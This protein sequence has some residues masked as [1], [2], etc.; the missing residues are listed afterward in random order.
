MSYG[1][2]SES[3]DR[4]NQSISRDV[5]SE[6]S[7]SRTPLAD[8]EL[9]ITSVEPH[10]ECGLWR[11]CAEVYTSHTDGGAERFQEVFSNAL[12]A[13]EDGGRLI[14]VSDSWITGDNR[15][16]S[17]LLR[18]LYGAMKEQ[19]LPV[20]WWTVDVGDTE[21]ARGYH[22]GCFS[23]YKAMQ[24]EKNLSIDPDRAREYIDTNR[25]LY[26][27]LREF[28][29]LTE[30]DW[31]MLVDIN[32]MGLGIGAADDPHRPAKVVE[33]LRIGNLGDNPVI[34][35]AWD[36]LDAL[37]VTSGIDSVLHLSSS[38]IP[39][40]PTH[41]S[42]GGFFLPQSSSFEPPKGAELLK[43][44]DLVHT[45][46]IEVSSVS[47]FW[48]SEE[49]SSFLH[50]GRDPLSLLESNAT[51]FYL[52]GRIDSSKNQALAIQAFGQMLERHPEY[53]STTALVLLSET[54]SAWNISVER[55]ALTEVL[56]E[57]FRVIDSLPAEAQ[58]RVAWFFVPQEFE[59]ER[60]NWTFNK[61]CQSRAEVHLCLSKAEGLPNVVF[62]SMN[63]GRVSLVTGMG[64]MK[65]Q[66]EHGTTGY[67]TPSL[68][69][70]D[71]AVAMLT[72]LEARHLHTSLGEAAQA[73]LYSEF[74]LIAYETRLLEVFMSGAAERSPGKFLRAQRD[75]VS[76][77]SSV[78][79]SLCEIE[80]PATSNLPTSSARSF[81]AL[82]AR[83]VDQV[84]GAMV[85][86]TIT[87][88]VDSV[89]EVYRLLGGHA[90]GFTRS[91]HTFSEGV[92][93]RL[94]LNGPL[95][96][97]NNLTVMVSACASKLGIDVT[98]HRD[99]YHMFAV[100][101]ERDGTRI[102]VEFAYGEDV[103]Q[104]EYAVHGSDVIHRDSG[105]VTFPLNA[106]DVHA[107]MLTRCSRAEPRLRGAVQ[108]SRRHPFRPWRVRRRARVVSTGRRARTGQHLLRAEQ[109]HLFGDDR[110]RRYL[111]S[112]LDGE[113]T[114]GGVSLQRGSVSSRPPRGGP[115][116]GVSECVGRD[117]G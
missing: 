81:D 104:A 15:G 33:N 62:E 86:G 35:D 9:F 51:I 71:V 113:A 20:E 109:Y 102:P 107:I 77:W 117:A 75:P 60:V 49:T 28:A 92:Q 47:E 42:I 114:H 46:S 73:K 27:K 2:G 93:H 68:E 94:H 70:T 34:V 101:E 37:G 36:Q 78:A 111:E 26:T 74:N 103:A 22:E 57:A 3:R 87:S 89:Q 115:G 85:L 112:R 116:V 40:K 17:F 45:Q 6:E 14:F 12:A 65:D 97:C 83:I 30:K 44:V 105:R 19:G 16:G 63:L 18:N 76:D 106:D 80:E 53:A 84:H 61:Y 88:N 59:D 52:P 54:P 108:Q 56:E 25:A 91:Y 10:Y 67:L 48:H 21:G 31:V 50:A 4:E 55:E 29:A 66:V 23:V 7:I 95:G 39:N 69:P 110:R 24:G 32:A 98:L 72:A 64:G 43:V 5:I 11:A 82:Q 8:V 79:R 58:S 96:D 13:L 41:D 1:L 38:Y 100:I 90:E 99:I